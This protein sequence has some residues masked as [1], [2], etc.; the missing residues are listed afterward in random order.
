MEDETIINQ[1][2]ILV[3]VRNKTMVLT[4]GPEAKLCDM[5]GLYLAVKA[6]GQLLLL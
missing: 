5:F 3:K 2:K 1:W 4:S 6:S